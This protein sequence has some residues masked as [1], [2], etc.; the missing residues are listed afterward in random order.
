MDK[1]AGVCW[2]E[3]RQPWVVETELLASVNLPLNLDQNRRHAF[4]ATLSAMRRVS[5]RRADELPV[6]VR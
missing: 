3:T 4:Q 1:N 5:K 6:W 2:I